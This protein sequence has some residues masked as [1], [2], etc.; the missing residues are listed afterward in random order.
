MGWVLAQVLLVLTLGLRTWQYLWLCLSYCTGQ[1]L[2]LC[3]LLSFSSTSWAKLIASRSFWPRSSPGITKSADSPVSAQC[4]KNSKAQNKPQA[5]GY[6][7]VFEIFCFVKIWG[8]NGRLKEA[9]LKKQPL[10]TTFYQMPITWALIE[11]LELFQCSTQP[12]HHIIGL[13]MGTEILT[14]FVP[15]GAV[16]RGYL[17]SHFYQFWVFILKKQLSLKQSKFWP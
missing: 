10:V 1:T 12:S 17:S 14:L 2:W 11:I 16:Q 6:M 3:E 8:H 4:F 7:L 5:L 9:T 15:V 13:V